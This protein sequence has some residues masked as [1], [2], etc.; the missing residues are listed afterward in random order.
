MQAVTFTAGIKKFNIKAGETGP[1]LSIE[2]S[3]IVGLNKKAQDIIDNMDG[4]LIVN[5]TPVQSKLEF[6]KKPEL[7]KEKP[8]K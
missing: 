6:G 2:L 7:P 1:E 5:F 4:A 8:K 3:G